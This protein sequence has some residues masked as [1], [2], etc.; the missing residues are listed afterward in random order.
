[1]KP[2]TVDEYIAL[3]PLAK[4]EMLEEM[5]SIIRSA[6]PKAEEV[7]SY[8]IPCYKLNGFLIGFGVHKKGCSFYAMH[9]DIGS[10]F[11]KEL[12]DIEH[13]AS[14][15]HFMA[16]KKL[17]AALIKKIIKFRVKQNLERSK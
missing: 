6:V 10:V 13:K 9:A 16:G 12:K 14:T 17:P 15:I 2:K 3:Q 7:V 4:R 5:R 11:P 8:M 1:M